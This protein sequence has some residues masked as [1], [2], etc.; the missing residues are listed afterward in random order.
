M[1]SAG[2]LLSRRPYVVRQFVSRSSQRTCAICEH[3]RYA[4]R[5]S[6]S[7]R[8]RQDHHDRGP[9]RTKLRTAL[10]HTKIQ[11]KPITIGLGIA[12]LGAVQFYRVRER[13]KRRQQKQEDEDALDSELASNNE[14][15]QMGRPI[16]RKKIRPSGP[17]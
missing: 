9:F 1:T 8:A 14:S 17:W 10:R 4:A 16:K 6:T 13:Q 7:A 15:D 12:F 5:L 3:S 11:W 2:G